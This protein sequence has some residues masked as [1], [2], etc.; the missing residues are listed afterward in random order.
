MAE[1]IT[2]VVLMIEGN[3][4]LLLS[5]NRYYIILSETGNVGDSIEFDPEKALPMPS[6]LFAIAAMAEENLDETLTFIQT[7]WFKK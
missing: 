5:Q 1:Q 7:K 6:Y 3:K 4:V 2:G